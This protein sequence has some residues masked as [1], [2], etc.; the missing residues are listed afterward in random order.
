MRASVADRASP[1]HGLLAGPAHDCRARGGHAVATARASGHA[2]CPRA[3]PRGRPRAGAQFG[4]CI[5]ATSANRSGAAAPAS[6][7]GVATARRRR[8]AARRGSGAR[9]RAVDDRRSRRWTPPHRTGRRDRLGPRARIRPVMR[10]ASS[11]SGAHEPRERAALV[12]LF[13]G[14]SRNFDPEHSLDELAGLATAAGADVRLRVLQ[15]RPKPDPAT[16]LGSGK[17]EAL[18]PRPTRPRSI[19]SSSTTS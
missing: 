19:P 15:E 9:R 5:T 4:E 3:G 8:S 14:P 13:T 2:W 18:A 6:A 12:G 1:R 11:R 10:T 7:A 16:F 17:V